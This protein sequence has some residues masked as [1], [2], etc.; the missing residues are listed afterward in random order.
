MDSSKPPSLRRRLPRAKPT[1]PPMTPEMAN[2]ARVMV[3]DWGYV[4]HQVAAILNVN[5]GRVNDAVHGRIFPS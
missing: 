2:Q 1:S 3:I 5:P 4:Q